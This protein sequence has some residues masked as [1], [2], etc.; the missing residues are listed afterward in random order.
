MTKEGKD[1]KF[2]F[3]SLTFSGGKK[4]EI[5]TNHSSTLIH[6]SAIILW[7]LAAVLVCFVGI[8]HAKFLDIG[9]PRLSWKTWISHLM[10]YIG[11]GALVSLTVMSCS[12]WLF[13]IILFFGACGTALLDHAI[14]FSMPLHVNMLNH[15]FHKFTFMFVG[16]C[17]FWMFHLIS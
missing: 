4:M 15:I 9:R 14:G 13:S 2:F 5:I 7:F 17:A 8:I 10:I 12:F 1:G 6:I 16:S 3:R 11:C